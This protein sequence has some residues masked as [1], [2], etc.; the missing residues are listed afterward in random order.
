MSNLVQF[1]AFGAGALCLG[2]GLALA[3]ILSLASRHSD[4]PGEGCLVWLLVMP[5]LFVSGVFFVVAVQIA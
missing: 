5:I 2:V 1:L 4:T 3:A